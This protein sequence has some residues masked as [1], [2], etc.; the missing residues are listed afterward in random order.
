MRKVE[1]GC[2]WR[3]L[4]GNQA[5]ITNAELFWLPQT[6]SKGC[7]CSGVTVLV[8]ESWYTSA[9]YCYR[10]RERRFEQFFNSRIV[11]QFFLGK[12]VSW[13]R[14]AV[15]KCVSIFQTFWGLLKVGGGISQMTDIDLILLNKTI[16]NEIDVYAA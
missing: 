2:G 8:C 12:Q 10:A 1:M 6:L 5:S 16:I 15:I 13:A 14:W 3:R 7:V 11:T 4:R 9:V